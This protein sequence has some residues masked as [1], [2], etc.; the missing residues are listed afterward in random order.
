M[1]NISTTPSDALF[2]SCTTFSKIFRAYC[3]PA[4]CLIALLGNVGVLFGMARV[5]HGF[6]K[7]VR[8]YYSVLALSELVLVD[9]YYFVGNWF[10]VGLS[11]IVSGG[12]YAPVLT[13]DAFDWSCRL[14]TALWVTSDTQS[15]LVLVFLS[16]ERVIAITWPLRAKS[17]L[18]LRFSVILMSIV[19]A[20]VVAIFLPLLL[21]VYEIVPGVG[22]SYNFSLPYAQ[23]YVI[24]EEM[25]PVVPTS[26][27]F[28]LSVY[29]VVKIASLM[30]ARRHLTGGATK[31]SAREMSNV[32]TVLILDFT[33]AISYIPFISLYL[34]A[35]VNNHLGDGS[36]PMVLYQIMDICDI[37]VMILHS[38]TFFIYFFRSGD[39]RTAVIGKRLSCAG[40]SKLASSTSH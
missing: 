6:I 9:G 5:E 21:L 30:R 32:F 15:D 16:V 40:E 10:E 34:Y 3:E 4:F 37:F 26:I 39:F 8:L 38:I 12:D 27:S 31:V 20:T 33:H 29:L 28:A 1:A 17:I 14:I 35:F 22:C 19:S 13:I 18:S 2:Q 36:F 7:S 11:Y 25:L 24:L 23:A